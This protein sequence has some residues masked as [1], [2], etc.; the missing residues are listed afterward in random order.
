MPRF[1]SKGTAPAKRHRY[2]T[3]CRCLFQGASGKKGKISKNIFPK[4]VKHM[5][6]SSYSET[7][8]AGKP[9]KLSMFAD[10][11]SP[12]PTYLCNRQKHFPFP[13]TI[14]FTRTRD[15][16][17]HSPAGF[18]RETRF[19]GIV[20]G[21]NRACRG[22]WVCAWGRSS[23]VRVCAPPRW[24]LSMRRTQGD[25]STVAAG[26]GRRAILAEE[27]EGLVAG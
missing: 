24:R 23:G 15:R 2:D 3:N 26:R 9:Q 25:H 16:E 1:P 12:L 7:T 21:G 10:R 5:P 6:N 27:D 14:P 20:H 19:L 11:P 18:K 13:F 4:T 22:R 17:P 8:R